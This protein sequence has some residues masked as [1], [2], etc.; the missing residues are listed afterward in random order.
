MSTRLMNFSSPNSKERFDLENYNYPLTM[1][2]IFFLKKFYLLKILSFFFLKQIHWF[3][4][5]GFDI[6]FIYAFIHHNIYIFWRPLP[7]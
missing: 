1:Q 7:F 5:Y 4:I 2:K 3:I 6:L